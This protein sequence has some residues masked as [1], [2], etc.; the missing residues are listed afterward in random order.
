MITI[1]TFFRNV[2]SMSHHD[3]YTV[4]MPI[5]H[6]TTFSW[7]TN[8]TNFDLKKKVLVV[9]SK[10]V[11]TFYAFK[12][13]NQYNTMEHGTEPWTSVYVIFIVCIIY[14]IINFEPKSHQIFLFPKSIKIIILDLLQWIY[15]NFKCYYNSYI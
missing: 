11:Y 2:V 12:N 3:L 4:T 10:L 14:L 13:N 6:S 1:I 9:K 15:G 7:E 5:K 8:N